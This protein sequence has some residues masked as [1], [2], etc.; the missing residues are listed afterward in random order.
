MLN[1]HTLALACRPEKEK[2]NDKIANDAREKK[3]EEKKSGTQM[4]RARRRGIG[5]C[6]VFFQFKYTLTAQEPNEWCKTTLGY[7]MVSFLIRLRLSYSFNTA[8]GFFWLLYYVGFVSFRFVSIRFL[9]LDLKRGWRCWRWRRGW[10]RRSRRRI[11]NEEEK[12]IAL[13]ICCTRFISTNIRY[14]YFEWIW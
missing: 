5:F 13:R 10:R 12:T 6:P 8:L 7:L 9:T 2:K 3:Y 11:E 1:K 4:G 14:W